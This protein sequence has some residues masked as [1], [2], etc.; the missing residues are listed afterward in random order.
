MK[1]FSWHVNDS[2]THLK[3]WICTSR[4]CK[5]QHKSL[6]KCNS[7]SDLWSTFNYH[8]QLVFRICSIQT[9][10]SNH[11]P[12]HNWESAPWI[13]L[14]ELLMSIDRIGSWS[15]FY[16][17]IRFEFFSTEVSRQDSSI[18]NH[19][20]ITYSYFDHDFRMDH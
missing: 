2:S 20:N 12:A 1:C 15:N 3:W 17:W 11:H 14:R 19:K 4:S 8:L 13:F 18:K 7:G 9:K 6:I 16:Y 5:L 10:L